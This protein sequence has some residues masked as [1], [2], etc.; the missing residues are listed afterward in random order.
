MNNTIDKKVTSSGGFLFFYNK[1]EGNIFVILIK[2]KKSEYWIP[3]GK[4]EN[5]E[6]QVDAAF[7]EIKEEVGFG[8]D[9]I[10]Y[11]DFCFLD[12]YIYE[13]E[14]KVIQKELYINVF[15]VY[16]KWD[17]TPEDW[18]N[19]DN[20]CWYKYEDAFNLISFNKDELIKAQ[21]IFKKY[22]NIS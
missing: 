17:P 3:K 10:K 2:N 7:R 6:S 9:K 18:N 5:D 11:I 19:I 13:D 8:S 20:V 14:G 1:E 12:K 21:N 16:K 22:K 4:L 15:E